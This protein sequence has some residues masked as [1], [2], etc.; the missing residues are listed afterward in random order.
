VV[1]SIPA[2]PTLLRLVQHINAV[3]SDYR[4]PLYDYD[5]LCFHVSIATVPPETQSQLDDIKVLPVTRGGTIHMP[6]IRVSAIHLSFGGG[7]KQY[8]IPLQE[9]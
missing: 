5:P 8:V 3:L 1:L 7:A 6:L 2:H 4:Q 9:T